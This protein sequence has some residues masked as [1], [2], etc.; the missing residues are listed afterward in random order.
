MRPMKISANS[1]RILTFAAKRIGAFWNFP[2]AKGR[3]PRF[4]MM[5]HQCFGGLVGGNMISNGG[6]GADESDEDK[7]AT[8]TLT[9]C[10]EGNS[11]SCHFTSVFS[12]LLRAMIHCALAIIHHSAHSP[13]VHT[14]TMASSDPASTTLQIYTPTC[15]YARTHG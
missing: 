4:E 7:W 6:N 8:G 12:S 14:I 1:L 2:A 5:S 13:Y 15:S 9:N 3:Q 11:G 10:T